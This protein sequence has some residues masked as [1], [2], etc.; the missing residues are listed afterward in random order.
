MTAVIAAAYGHV[1]CHHASYGM[2]C[3]EFDRLVERAAGRCEYCGIP[4][5]ETPRRLLCIDHDGR[6]GD[7]A[8]RGLICDKCNAHMRRVDAGERP[9]DLRSRRY[10]RQS[11]FMEV[12]RHRQGTTPLIAAHPDWDLWREFGKATPNR[13]GL[14]RDFIAWYVRRPGTRMP[15]RPS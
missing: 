12:E 6:Y 8:V 10:Y 3:Q 2:S 15:R 4:E 1:T 9:F 5:E 11:W 13:R 14:V 7:T